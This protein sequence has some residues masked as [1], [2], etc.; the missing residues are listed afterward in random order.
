MN[1][2]KLEIRGNLLNGLFWVVQCFRAL[3]FDWAWDYWLSS[4][5]TTNRERA[6]HNKQIQ[7]EIESKTRQSQLKPCSSRI[8]TTRTKYP[9]LYF[10]LQSL[11]KGYPANSDT[12]VLQSK[13]E[14]CLAKLSSIDS[15]LRNHRS[16][17]NKIL[18]PNVSC[19][20]P[21]VLFY[22][23]DFNCSCIVIKFTQKERSIGSQ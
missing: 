5:V 13:S 16:T 15:Q 17:L 9:T 21:N 8:C 23:K 19:E 1:I 18:I 6:H 4:S 12:Q 22:S 7:N 11:N 2:T 20:I 14:L 10:L 3:I